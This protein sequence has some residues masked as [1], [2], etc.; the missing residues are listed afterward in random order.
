MLSV[1]ADQN[2]EINIHFELHNTSHVRCNAD[3]EATDACNFAEC[4]ECS[5]WFSLQCN[6]F[7]EVDDM[8]GEINSNPDSSCENWLFCWSF[9]SN[10]RHTSIN[11]WMRINIWTPSVRRRRD[12]KWR[13]WLR[14]CLEKWPKFSLPFWP[15]SSRKLLLFCFRFR[16]VLI[17]Y[18]AKRQADEFCILGEYFIRLLVRRCAAIPKI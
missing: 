10:F 15:I 16:L 8:D 13:E 18:S 5:E 17:P 4:S 2:Y 11:S 1:C 3:K 14:Q 7:T 12:R 6:P 9:R